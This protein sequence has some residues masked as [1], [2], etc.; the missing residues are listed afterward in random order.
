MF[1]SAGI[2]QFTGEDDEVMKIWDKILLQN[3]IFDNGRMRRLLTL[4]LFYKAGY[5]VGKYVMLQKSFPNFL[6][7][8]HAPWLW[9][10]NNS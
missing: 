9:K 2:A 4:L 6:H 8:S 10:D 1:G 3:L 7:S 5:I